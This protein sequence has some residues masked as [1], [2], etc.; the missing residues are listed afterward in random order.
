[1]AVRVALAV[2]GAGARGGVQADHPVLRGALMG[3]CIGMLLPGAEAPAELIRADLFARYG[4]GREARV[5]PA[6]AFAGGCGG[7]D[8]GRDR[9]G[10]A[11][12]VTR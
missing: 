5:A 7:K 8:G 9:R 10:G 11:V 12:R 4:L 1:M 2:R 6:G 3:A